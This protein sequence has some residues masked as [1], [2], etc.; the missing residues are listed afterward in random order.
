[1]TESF[2]ADA[3]AKSREGEREFGSDPGG[4]KPD[5]F[6]SDGDHEWKGKTDE[7]KFGSFSLGDVFD[8]EIQK[9]GRFTFKGGD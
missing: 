8:R 6:S 7:V 2:D 4:F 1:V 3:I 5:S 9:F